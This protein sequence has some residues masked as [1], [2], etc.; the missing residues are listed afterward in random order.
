MM[1]L[2]LVLTSQEWTQWR[3]PARDGVVPAAQVPAAWPKELKSKWKVAVGGGY[4]T[5]VVA[6]GAVFLH[7]RSG[8]SETVSRFSLASGKLEWT[9]SY[10]AVFNKN[11]YAKAMSKGPF[12]TPVVREGRLYTLGVTAILSV[13]D[14]RTGCLL[15]TSPSPRD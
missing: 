12:S 4:S 6:A 2:L 3:G 8:E 7:S 14:V 13:W 9:K 10:P 11:S 5:P 1:L 15:Y